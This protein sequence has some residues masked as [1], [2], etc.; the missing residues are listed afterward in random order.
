MSD[1]PFVKFSGLR[2]YSQNV[3]KKYAWIELLLNE[4]LNLSDIIFI[5]EPLWGRICNVASMTDNVGDPIMGM[6]KHPAW[7]RFFPKP[8]DPNLN[9]D[10]PRVTAFVHQCLWAMKPKLCSDIFK[11]QDIMLLTLNGL[12][13]QLHM[14]N[15][16]SDSKG[17]AIRALQEHRSIPSPI[18]YL[19]GDF[20]CPSDRW[21]PE[22]TRRTSPFA[23]SLED[24]VQANGLIYQNLGCATHFPENGSHPST[25]DLVFLPGNDQESRFKVGKRGESDH[26]PILTELRFP[27]LTENKLPNI[28]VGSEADTEFTNDILK[29]IASIA[30]PT[31]TESREDITHVTTLVS[32]CLAK[33]WK[34]HATSSRTSVRS[35]GWWDESC[36][37]A[38]R[39]YQKSDCSSEE[40]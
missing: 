40:W 29:S 8:A 28:K 19:G 3:Y 35:K 23:E 14:L 7:R 16:Y 15:V 13:G 4:H 18:G 36:M 1:T 21:D 30:C 25:I 9:S 5:Q 12:R 11:S 27:V 22:W 24:F 2:V 34:A 10:R 6:L 39:Q 20:N 31:N 26:C 37:E 38:M 33:A 32:E 17:S